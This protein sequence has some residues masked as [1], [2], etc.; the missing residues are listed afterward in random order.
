MVDF[1]FGIKII[2]H[3][4][5]CTEADTWFSATNACEKQKRANFSKE[6]RRLFS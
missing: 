3:C 4:I 2:K 6:I 5:Y 1:V